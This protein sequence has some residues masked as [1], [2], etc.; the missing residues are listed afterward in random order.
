VK[1]INVSDRDIKFLKTRIIQTILEEHKMKIIGNF[2]VYKDG[3]LRI[4]YKKQ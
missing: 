3:R 4:R 2:S 1:E